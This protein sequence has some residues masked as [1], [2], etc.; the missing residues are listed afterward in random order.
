M[1]TWA[2]LSVEGFSSTGLK[3]V[4]GGDAGGQRLQRLGAADLATIDG[5]RRIQAMFCGLNGA[6]REPR[7]L[8]MRHSAATSVVLPASEVQP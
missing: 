6:T 5:Y 2:R 4:C 8:R 7:R 1:I 3:S